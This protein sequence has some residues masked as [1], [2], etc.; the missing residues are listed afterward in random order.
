VQ[1]TLVVDCPEELQ[2]QRAAARSG[3]THAEVGAIMATQLRRADRDD[4]ADDVLDNSGPPAAIAPQVAVLD[5]R[6]RALAADRSRTGMRCLMARGTW[7]RCG[8]TA[9]DCATPIRYDLLN[10]RIRTLMRSRISSPRAVSRLSKGRPSTALLAL[11]E[12]SDVAA[13]ATEDRHAAGAER[14]NSCSPLRNNLAIET[15]V[16]GRCS[17][18]STGQCP[19]RAGGPGGRAS[20]ET[21]G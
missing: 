20:A 10:E 18:R 3:L 17:P 14:Q 12:I 13:R 15:R 11:F 1:R 7:R 19:A 9:H 21:S 2:P 5:R 4:R 8:T 6:Y 16:L